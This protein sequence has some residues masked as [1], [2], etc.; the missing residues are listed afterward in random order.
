MGQKKHGGKYLFNLHYDTGLC[1]FN[2]GCDHERWHFTLVETNKVQCNL[3]NALH[4][5]IHV[6]IHRAMHCIVVLCFV[7]LLLLLLLLF[8]LLFTKQRP[9]W[10]QNVSNAKQMNLLKEKLVFTKGCVKKGSNA[11]FWRKKAPKIC[12]SAPGS[13]SYIFSQICHVLM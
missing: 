12:S 6:L 2:V 10:W 1:A 11:P 7:S 9:R 4:N 8:L 3:E 5:I 13:L